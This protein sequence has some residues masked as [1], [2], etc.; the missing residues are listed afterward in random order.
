MYPEGGDLIAGL[1]CR[2][3]IEALTPAK[4]PADLKG[5]IVDSKGNEIAAFRTEHEGRGRFEL[6]PA[7][8]EPYTLTIQ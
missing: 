2:V 6:P 3:Y 4:K 7:K 1:P 5:I 8:G